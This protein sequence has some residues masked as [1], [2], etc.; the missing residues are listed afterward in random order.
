MHSERFQHELAPRLET[1][2]RRKTEHDMRAMGSDPL[3]NLQGE[4]EKTLLASGNDKSSE[5]S[6]S[7]KRK[8][9]F[10]F[11]KSLSKLLNTL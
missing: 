7:E 1:H 6:L 10:E 11:K 9:K 5:S 2:K 4:E 8:N 3:S